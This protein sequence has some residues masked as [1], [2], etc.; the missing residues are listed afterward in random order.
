MEEITY[1]YEGRCPQNGEWV[2]LPR[3]SQ[4]EA[5]AHQLMQQL[6]TDPH[7]STEGKMYGVLLA[8]SSSGEQVV[9]K[10]FSG[11]WQGNAE[12]PG[13]V[14]PIP[15]REQVALAEAQTLSQLE[16]MKQELLTLKAL[17]E[18]SQYEQLAQA[19]T[20]RLPAM[21][22][23][24]QQRK[25]KRHQQRQI[26]S[27]TSTDDALKQALLELEKE[28]QQDGIERR[29]LKRQR[30]AA[31]NSLKRII[32][33]ADERIQ[34][35]KRE[36]K[37]LS[38]QLQSQMHEAYWLANFAGE[39]RSLPH[40]IPDGMP[41]GTGDCCAP[42]LLHYA[43]T[44]GLNPLAMAEF[45]WGPP[46]ANGSRQSGKFY[47]A[48]EERCQPLMGFLLSGLEQVILGA[49]NPS[50]S[51][52]PLDSG[53]EI[54]YKDECL[55]A[56]N[57]PAGLLSVPGRYRHSQD[58]AL[59]RLRC[60]LPNGEALKPV[61]RLDQDTSGILVL[62]RTVE[63]HRHLSQQFQNR[64]VHKIYEALLIGILAIESG[65]IHLPLCSDPANR[66]RRMVDYRQGKPSTTKFRLLAHEGNLSRVEFIPITGR[67]H[68]LRVHAAHPDGLGLPIWGDRL[69]GLSDAHPTKRL[70]LHAR[71]LHLR[72]PHTET[73]LHFQAPVPF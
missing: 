57:K 72:H 37:A 66:P 30:D 64:Q 68:Q 36:R 55:I 58:S 12:V 73:D 10:A 3:T 32:A 9:L 43:A 18:R 13:W 22:D 34:Q 31:L 17:P 40:L 28:S 54:L 67:T 47:G 5:I 15:G 21:G 33:Q 38:Q 41:T 60:Q 8:E 52:L 63:A 69:Y 70:H 53:L 25:Q 1:W 48:C 4:V 45:W 39:R 27:K 7:C 51:Q 20:Q 59:S 56:V 42:K 24:H 23:R 44:H 35:L 61:H 62:A 29:N 26:L 14:P 19:F 49:D 46:P 6:A 50:S 65:E 16:A 71:E 2:R 11:L